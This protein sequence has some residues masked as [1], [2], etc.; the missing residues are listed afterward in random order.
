VAFENG[1]ARVK[2]LAIPVLAFG[3]N[4]CGSRQCSG[5]QPETCDTS[6][7]LANVPLAS[8]AHG[9]DCTLTLST[10]TQSATYDF[11]A[12]P[13]GGSAPACATLTGPTPS[14]CARS[15]A[16]IV[17]EFSGTQAAMFVQDL[18]VVGV[19]NEAFSVSLACGDLAPQVSH[20]ALCKP[21]S[22]C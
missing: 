17:I 9:L 12:S 20:Q 3:A 8:Q 16:S 19:V 22:N 10:A 15:A 13:D 1:C 5:Y 6:D 21:V 4:G 14:S 2:W 11:P 18:H 7:I